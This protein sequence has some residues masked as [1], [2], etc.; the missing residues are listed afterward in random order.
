MLLNRTQENKHI[1]NWMTVDILRIQCALHFFV[2]MFWRVIV[3]PKYLK[4]VSFSKD[5]LANFIIGFSMWSFKETNATVNMGYQVTTTDTSFSK[6]GKSLYW[7]SE[8]LFEGGQVKQE[9]NLKKLVLQFL[10]FPS[11][12]TTWLI[13]GPVTVM[14]STRHFWKISE[15][16]INWVVVSLT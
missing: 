5:L 13:I 7:P 3:V 8:F 2:N 11:T 12:V 9:S 15:Q 14:S 1:L 10:F 4:C 16:N 6:Y